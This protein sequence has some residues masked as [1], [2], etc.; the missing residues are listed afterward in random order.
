[1]K[2][3]E[4]RTAPYTDYP[5]NRDH[6][7]DA[8]FAEV[9]WTVPTVL[10]N[11]VRFHIPGIEHVE[12]WVWNRF[13]SGIPAAGPGRPGA[14]GIR[15]PGACVLWRALFRTGVDSSLSLCIALTV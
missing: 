14:S 13:Y 1:M 10:V 3:C 6:N 8:A 4:R 9:R 12:I 2:R 7:S 5:A 11:E 15:A